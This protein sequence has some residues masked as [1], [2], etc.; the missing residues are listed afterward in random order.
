MAVVSIVAIDRDVR[1]EDE[2]LVEGPSGDT[3]SVT[4]TVTSHLLTVI[5]ADIVLQVNKQPVLKIFAKTSQ[6]TVRIIVGKIE[7]GDFELKQKEGQYR[8]QRLFSPNL[9]S[10]RPDCCIVSQ[11]S[12]V[13]LKIKMLSSPISQSGSQVFFILHCI[14]GDIKLF[15]F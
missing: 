11:D 12:P 15:F 13:N 1:S 14:A 8:N 10:A 5:Q 3:R 7:M 4:S 2:V 9:Y 6:L